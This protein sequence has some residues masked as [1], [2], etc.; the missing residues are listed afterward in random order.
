[1]SHDIINI[2]ISSLNHY[3]NI[4]IKIYPLTNSWLFNRQDEIPAETASSAFVYLQA[5]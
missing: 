4:K 5:F 2:N 3:K 1:M